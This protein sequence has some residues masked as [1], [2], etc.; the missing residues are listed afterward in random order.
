MNPRLL[1]YYVVPAL[2]ALNLLLAAV[3]WAVRP[4]LPVVWLAALS[5][6]GCMTAAWAGALGRAGGEPARRRT[7]TVSRSVVLASA[8]VAGSLGLTLATGLGLADGQELG[9]RGTMIVLGLTLMAIGNSLPKRLTPLALMRCDAARA[10]SFHRV[11]GWT[12]ALAGLALAT[13]WLLWPVDVAKPASMLAI[14]AALLILVAQ[15]FRVRLH[16]A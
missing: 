15:A 8:V 3:N 2:L 1:S 9:Q 13:V 6:L 16:G 5:L 4:D 11:A 7:E 10:Q 14:G 12:W